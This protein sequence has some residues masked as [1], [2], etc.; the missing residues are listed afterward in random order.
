MDSSTASDSATATVASGQAAAAAAAPARSHPLAI[1]HFRN[2][3]MGAT[4]SLLGDQFY[5]VALPWLVLQITG[6]S[7]VLG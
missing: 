3:W 1:P 2:L 6:S 4:I 5:L 7:L